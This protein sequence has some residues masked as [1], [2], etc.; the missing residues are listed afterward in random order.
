MTRNHSTAVTG[1]VRTH[2]QLFEEAQPGDYQVNEGGD[3]ILCNCPCGCGSMMNLPIAT[4]EKPE[5]KWQWDGNREHPTLAP[6]IRD[7]N[8]C[9]WHGHLQNGIWTPQPDSGAGAGA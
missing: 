3:D 1:R 2:E 9:R 4:G 7:M 6:S 5:H 8:G